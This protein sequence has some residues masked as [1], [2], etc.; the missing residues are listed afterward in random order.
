[1]DNELDTSNGQRVVQNWEING[2]RGEGG[3]ETMVN[4]H[5]MFIEDAPN[6]FL[7]SI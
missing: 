3:A 4:C 7:F 6:H 1:M 2:V 5:Y